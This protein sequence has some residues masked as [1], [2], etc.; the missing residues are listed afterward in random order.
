MKAT[1]NADMAEL[2]DALASGASPRKRVE[3]QV[4]LSAPFNNFIYYISYADMAESADALASGAS[5]R[6]GV[7]VQVLLSAFYLFKLLNYLKKTGFPVFFCFSSYLHHDIYKKFLTA[8]ADLRRSAVFLRCG[9][10][11]KKSDASAAMLCRIIALLPFSYFSI[12]AV[13]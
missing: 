10:D 9:S 8:V 11:R 5:P 1:K 12:E 4:L 6:K 3:V 2:A 13:C 7:E